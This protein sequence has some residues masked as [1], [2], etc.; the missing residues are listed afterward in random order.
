MTS[1]SLNSALS[2]LKA[3]QQALNT[4][5]A[6]IA[7]ASTP[8]Y[9]RKIL[10]QSTLIV[11][12][13]AAGV[14]TGGL[15]RNVDKTLMKSLFGQVSTTQ[16]ALVRT[17]YLERVQDF[18]GASELERTFS[19]RIGKLSDAFTA[20]SSS[21][22]N[23]IYLNQTVQAAEILAKTFNDYT[24][25][26]NDLR[27]QAERE[28]SAYTAD[29]NISLEKIAALNLQIAQLTGGG[30]STAD[31]EDQRDTALR[32]VSQYMQ[33]STYIDQNNVM[34]VST[35]QGQLLADTKAQKLVFNAAANLTPTSHYP[36]GGLNGLYINST[37][38]TE[39]SQGA[40]GG[41]LGALFELRDQTLPQYQAQADELAQK[42]AERFDTLGLRLFTDSSGNVPASV[43][44]PAPVTYSGFAGDIRVNS[45]IVNDPTLLRNG[46]NGAAV[47]AGSNSVINRINSFAF[48]ATAAQN[49]LGTVDITGNVFA[50]TGLT[51][52]NR[53]TGNV[54]LG[55]YTPDLGAASNITL[56]AA[57]SLTVGGVPQNIVINPGDTA[58]DLVNSINTAFGAGT[59]AINQLGQLSFNTTSDISIADGVPG[60]GAAGMADLGFS[61]GTFAADNPSFSVSVNGQP[62][63]TITILPTDTETDLLNKLNTITGL[64]AVQGAGGVLQITPNEGGSLSFQN[65]TGTP[66]GAL[67]VT[68]NNVPHPSFRQNNLGPA[69]NLSSGLPANMSISDYGKNLV[70]MQ[71]ETYNAAQ[72]AYAQEESFLST[73]DARN[74]AISGVDIDTEIA[75][76]I[77]IQTAYTAA[78]RIISATERL[79]DDLLAAVR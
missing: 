78:A 3:A 22:D 66:V 54:N 67:G 65:V 14:S 35:K 58:A 49:A 19:A 61:F 9:T 5:S 56:P 11:N 60:I 17:N 51:Q 28:I 63:V 57:F 47:N 75:E 6:N 18:H 31:L 23:A 39:I 20:L 1:V 36:N 46:T 29:L 42:M 16:S 52:I 76:L 44:P 62:P 4:V 25:M 53:L 38:G 73:L 37:G 21:P 13:T 64:T 24:T 50:A 30:Q 2:G 43:A 70:T 40:I 59:A 27:V 7:N 72:S 79:F 41:A 55:S 26:I 45:N 48:G 33:V 68:I 74:S 34:V 8:G 77:R 15:V 71:S 10:P 32:N 12:G 69:G